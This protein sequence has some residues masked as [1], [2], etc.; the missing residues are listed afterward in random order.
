MASRVQGCGFK[1]DRYRPFP[2]IVL[3][4]CDSAAVAPTGTDFTGFLSV[5]LGLGARTVIAA[6][7]AVPDVNETS[8]LMIAFHS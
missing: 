8:E 7:T 5:L 6:T 2:L 3:A 1:S 4:A